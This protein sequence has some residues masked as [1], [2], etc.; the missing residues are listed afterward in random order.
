M[1]E[2]DHNRTDTSS[3]GPFL[4]LVYMVC[5]SCSKHTATFDKLFKLYRISKYCLSSVVT[6]ISITTKTSQNIM[7]KQRHLHTFVYNANGL[8]W[9]S[10][11]MHQ[12]IGWGSSGLAQIFW[13]HVYNS[14]GFYSLPLQ[15]RGVTCHES[16]GFMFWGTAA[17][18]GHFSLVVSTEAIH[19]GVLFLSYTLRPRQNGHHFPDDIFKSIFLNENV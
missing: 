10:F 1:P 12:I 4:A 2:R 18:I 9:E 16:M 7:G 15:L 13:K 14:A 11:F 3:V 8:S 17:W 5:L 19:V 6:F